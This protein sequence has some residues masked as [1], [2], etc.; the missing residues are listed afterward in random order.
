M[1][2]NRFGITASSLV[3]LTDKGKTKLMIPQAESVKVVLE[4]DGTEIDTDSFLKTLP[5]HTVVVLLRSGETWTGVVDLTYKFR[6]QPTYTELVDQIRQM[7]KEDRQ[8]PKKMRLMLQFLDTLETKVDAEMRNEHEDWFEGVNKKYKSKSKFMRNLAQERM[9][10]YFRK[11]KEQMDKEKDPLVKAALSEL[12]QDVQARL[13]GAD[14]HGDY[15]DRCAKAQLRI[16]DEKG[17]FQCQGAFDVAEC[18]LGHTI[19]PYA[20]R[21]FRLMF[22]LWELD[23]IIEKSREIVPTVIKAA[24]ALPKDRQL[25]GAVLHRLLFTLDN[26][27]LVQSEC[28]KKAARPERRLDLQSFYID[29]PSAEGH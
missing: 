16:C 5:Q 27:K 12:L 10:K 25:N 9:K 13:K 15:F 6:H 4:D 28:H 24:Q 18:I 21:D 3:E 19:N 23:H 17:F 1:R 14:Y 29:L 26:L 2:K 7:L 11:A 20:S 8:A 22:K